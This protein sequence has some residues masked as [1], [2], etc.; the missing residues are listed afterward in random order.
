MDIADIRRLYRIQDLLGLRSHKK[1]DLICPLPM[2]RHV[3]YTPSFS[4]FVGSDGVQRFK[5][6]G[7]CDVHGTVIDLAGFMWVAGYS[8][9]SKKDV[10]K[11]VDQL[12]I[13]GSVNIPEREV[14]ATLIA[15]DAHKGYEPI[16]AE[17]RRFA[18]S[19]GLN[20]G[21]IEEFELGQ[22]GHY[23]TMPYFRE[24]RLRGIKKRKWYDKARWRYLAEEGSRGDLFNI[25][26]VRHTNSHVF[27]AKAELPCML[28]NQW[29]FKSVAPTGGE[30]SWNAD[31]RM[32][33]GLSRVTVIGD[34]DGPGRRL[35]IKRAQ[36]FGAALEFP[37]PEYKDV[38]E[39]MLARP[40][41]AR[42]WLQRL[43]H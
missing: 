19:R 3:N 15:H 38:D 7:N 9:M 22:D 40:E 26:N 6:H 36:L 1:H 31:W 18:H 20:D 13:R 42:E 41:E 10:K 4:I 5:C 27:V 11:A 39:Y 29:G 28:L 24:G 35:G 32:E 34:N 25:D 33:L 17:A 43:S 14:R 16:G 8:P 30:G 12:R 2:H 37:A 23:L 21:T